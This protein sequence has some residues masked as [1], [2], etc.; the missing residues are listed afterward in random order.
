MEA[1]KNPN[2]EGPF[3]TKEYQKK[4][5]RVLGCLEYIDP[6]RNLKEREI[7]TKSINLYTGCTEEMI[8][9]AILDTYTGNPAISTTLESTMQDAPIK[10]SEE[11]IVKKVQAMLEKKTN[12]DE[13]IKHLIIPFFIR[14]QKI[15][16]WDKD[17][18]QERLNQIDLKLDKIGFEKMNDLSTLGDT[19]LDTIRLNSKVF[20]NRQRK[21]NFSCFS[22]SFS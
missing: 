4:A 11:F 14:S 21:T 18:F 16:D 5:A 20:L 8:K 22:N 10:I 2:F 12:Y 6:I 17:E 7:L 13:R 1:K 3:K 9:S 19:S 15:Y